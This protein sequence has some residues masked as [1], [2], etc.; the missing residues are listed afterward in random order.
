MK[1]DSAHLPVV[2][3]RTF[4]QLLSLYDNGTLELNPVFQ[5]SSV[6][7][8][9]D[10]SRFLDSLLRGY[11]VPAV[12]LYER[13]GEKNKRIL[14][15]IDGKQRIESVF[16]FMGILKKHANNGYVATLSRNEDGE[17]V[18]RRLAW[19][20]L[21]NEERR[22]ILHAQVPV[23]FVS[24][25]LGTICDVF[26]R[27]NSTGK[28]LTTGEIRK[29]KYLDSD[30]LSAVQG[31]ANSVQNLLLTKKV[32][33]LEQI[34]RMED[35]SLLA[36]LAIAVYHNQVKDKKKAVEKE[37][38]RKS[39]DGRSIPKT[40]KETAHAIRFTCKSLLPDIGLTRFRKR[41]DFYSLTF[42]V[43]KLLK[44]GLAEKNDD[45]I[46]KARQLLNEFSKETQAVALRQREFRSIRGSNPQ[47]LEYLRSVQS[48]SD[49]YRE[50]TIRHDTLYSLLKPVLVFKDKR[51]LYT[52]NQRSFVFEQGRRCYYCGKKLTRADFTVDHVIP[53]A[54]GGQTTLANARPCCRRCNSEKGAK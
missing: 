42:L 50:R 11:P 8:P 28:P 13:K 31:L 9:G 41:S 49:G 36:D 3:T 52:S 2:E 18:R 46:I 6:W 16:L 27:I 37:L 29:A 43:S 35:V 38:T 40:I 30:F 44:D 5:R 33:T 14:D 32:L 39:I 20:D 25:D 19:D 45:A 47:I 15:V 22:R 51:R 10:R 17:N 21:T 7:R 4:S 1:T 26:V 12:F 54:K 53:Y 34:D 48:N 24:G 23:I